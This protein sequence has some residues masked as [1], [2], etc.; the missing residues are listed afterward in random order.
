MIWWD[1]KSVFAAPSGGKQHVT[2]PMRALIAVS[3]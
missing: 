1:W 3:A 2:K